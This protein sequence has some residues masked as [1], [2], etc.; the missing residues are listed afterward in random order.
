QE[1]SD[2]SMTRC[3]QPALQA[4][5]CGLHRLHLAYTARVV[6]DQFVPQRAPGAQAVI[7]GHVMEPQQQRFRH[8]RYVA[9]T[10]RYSRRVLGHRIAALPGPVEADAIAISAVVIHRRPVRAWTA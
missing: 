2:L 3:I 1:G 5:P 10:L 6:V 8:A 9:E 4:V 7:P